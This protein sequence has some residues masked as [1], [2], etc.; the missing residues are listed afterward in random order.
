M[1]LLRA[2]YRRRTSPRL[3]PVQR[4]PFIEDQPACQPGSTWHTYTFNEWDRGSKVTFEKLPNMSSADAG[5]HGYRLSV[6]GEVRT[7]IRFSGVDANYTQVTNGRCTGM[8]EPITNITECSTAA[9]ALNGTWD[10]NG[11]SYSSNPRAED[12][13]PSASSSPRGCYLSGDPPIFNAPTGMWAN[14]RSLMVDVQ[15]QNTG[16]CKFDRVCICRRVRLS[17]APPAAPPPPPPPATGT[18]LTSLSLPLN[19]C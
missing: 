2:H 9:I 15:A 17:P 8:L 10:N 16:E 19:Q 5:A 7:E 11:G 12:D 3:S 6:D 4:N 13:G 1:T 18:S 14:T